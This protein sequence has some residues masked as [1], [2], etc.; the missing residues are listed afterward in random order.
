MLDKGDFVSY[1][2]QMEAIEA[3]MIKVYSKC[4]LLAESEDLK[5]VFLGLVD[6]ENRHSR[7]VDS[8]KGFFL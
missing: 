2:E 8:L 3:S 6:D 1:L 7:M 5:K 4:A